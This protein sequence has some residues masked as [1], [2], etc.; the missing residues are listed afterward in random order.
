MP[1]PPPAPRQPNCDGTQ[2]KGDPIGLCVPI[3]DAMSQFLP[4]A[5]EEPP[6]EAATS[7]FQIVPAIFLSDLLS[8][9]SAHA[10]RRSRRTRTGLGLV[11]VAMTANVLRASIGRTTRLMYAAAHRGWHFARV[12]TQITARNRRSRLSGVSGSAIAAAPIKSAHHMRAVARVFR[13]GLADRCAALSR[14][15]EIRPDWRAR[16]SPMHVLMVSSRLATF[17]VGIAVGAAVMWSFALRP[18]T[19]VVTAQ[20]TLPSADTTAPVAHVRV[21]TQALDASPKDLPR[22]P[23]LR[24][25]SAVA[26]KAT[27]VADASS[28]AERRRA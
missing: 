26:A 3:E 13:D 19:E 2:P 6:D 8:A 16:I 28:Y 21:T 17:S 1:L 27:A 25:I 22:E 12:L 4:E 18:Q 14:S 20:K 10:T 9:A 15:V 11:L 7:I 24:A 5:P 23:P